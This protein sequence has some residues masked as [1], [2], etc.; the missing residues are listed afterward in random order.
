MASASVRTKSATRTAKQSHIANLVLK[1]AQ[2]H[3]LGV[4][5]VTT[6]MLPCR[7]RHRGRRAS[8]LR[9]QA[10]F[11]KKPGG[12]WLPILRKLYRHGTRMRQI[13]V[14]SMQSRWPSR[15]ALGNMG[16]SEC[17]GVI[18]WGKP[19]TVSLVALFKQPQQTGTL[20]HK[21]DACV[22]V[23]RNCHI[24]RL[25]LSWKIPDMGVSLIKQARKSG[26]FPLAS[27]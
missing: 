22:A 12:G 27:L 25:F 11:T 1:D 14:A 10:G 6:S 8:W 3:A 5:C 7:E 21:K 18:L 23:W 17:P 9:K 4:F 16:V 19:A 2:T 15:R 13:I 26:W 24:S 20:K